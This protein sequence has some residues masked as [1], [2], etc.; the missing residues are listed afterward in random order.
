MSTLHERATAAFEGLSYRLGRQ[1]TFEELAE[2]VSGQAGRTIPPSTV[3][4]WLRGDAKS[5]KVADVEALAAAL[6]VAPAFLAWGTRDEQ[7]RRA[8]SQTIVPAVP[9][10]ATKKGRS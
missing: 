5:M 6:E 8:P 4:R 7:F 1:L 10:A 9:K 2:R 3:W